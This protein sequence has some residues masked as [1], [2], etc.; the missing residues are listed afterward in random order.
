V[1]LPCRLEL[2]GLLEVPGA[3]LA[4]GGA[5]VAVTAGLD[6]VALLFGPLLFPLEELLLLLPL[7]PMPVPAATG[8]GRSS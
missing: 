1:R 7:V 6:P 5:E 3:L 2:A 4:G 8:G